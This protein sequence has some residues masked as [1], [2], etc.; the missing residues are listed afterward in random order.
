MMRKVRNAFPLLALCVLLISKIH[1]F[2]RPLI[3]VVNLAPQAKLSLAG[4]NASTA[5]AERRTSG[6]EPAADSRRAQ[7]TRRAC[8]IQHGF[9]R[10]DLWRTIPILIQRGRG[11]EVRLVFPKEKGNTYTPTPQ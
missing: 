6:D 11:V 8:Q 7:K 10:V 5:K 2:S 1:T 4:Q 9:I 3:H